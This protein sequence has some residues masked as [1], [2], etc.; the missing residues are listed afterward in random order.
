MSDISISILLSYE[1]CCKCKLLYTQCGLVR[2][3]WIFPLVSFLNFKHFLYSFR[4]LTLQFYS[5]R[6]LNF[7]NFCSVIYKFNAFFCPIFQTIRHFSYKNHF[8]LEAF[9]K[10]TY[11]KMFSYNKD[12]CIVSKIFLSPLKRCFLLFKSEL[13]AV[14]YNSKDQPVVSYKSVS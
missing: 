8:D 1:I 6:F 10:K 13:V 5:H 12:N 2:N 3:G 14:S 4:F 9:S 11:S 7:L